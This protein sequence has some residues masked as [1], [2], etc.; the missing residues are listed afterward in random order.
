MRWASKPRLSILR[1]NPQAG[2]RAIAEIMTNI[3]EDGVKYQLDKLKKE[4][5][6]ERVGPAK[7][8][9]WKILEVKE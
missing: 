5:V 1:E 9:Y 4:G 2:R 8:G 3:T 6:I 7:G